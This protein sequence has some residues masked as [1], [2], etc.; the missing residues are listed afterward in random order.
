MTSVGACAPAVT[1]PRM[2]YMLLR[3]ADQR[4]AGREDHG[5]GGTAHQPE[6]A[7]VAPFSYSGQRRTEG[8]GA[9][10]REWS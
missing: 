3:T 6:E 8:G 7:Q 9:P 2:A 10:A 1:E 5:C 4:G